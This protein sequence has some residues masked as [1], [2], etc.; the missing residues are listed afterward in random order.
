VVLTLGRDLP[1]R[2]LIAF[3]ALTEADSFRLT[4]FQD[5]NPALGWTQSSGDVELTGHFR[6]SPDIIPAR[7]ESLGGRG[8][9]HRIRRLVLVHFAHHGPPAIPKR[10]NTSEPVSAVAN[11]SAERDQRDAGQAVG[12]YPLRP[13]VFPQTNKQTAA[14]NAPSPAHY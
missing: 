11:P 13:S 5:R 12:C 2:S 10:L 6:P 3:A 8:R 7:R 14:R 4:T 9:R 1:M